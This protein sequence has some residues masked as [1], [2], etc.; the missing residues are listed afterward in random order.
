MSRRFA[1]AAV[2]AGLV[3]A[4]VSGG[5]AWAGAR[6]GPN[7][8]FVGYVNGKSANAVVYTA[9]PGPYRPG[10]LGPPVGDHVYVTRV[11]NGGGDTGANARVIYAYVP[12]GPPA[13]TSL[14]RYGNQGTLP[15]TARV[16]CQG[17]GTVYFTTCPLP[18]PCGAGAKPYDVS[19][20]F[21]NIAV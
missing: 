5:V 18:Q 8:H 14:S 12:G 9:C 6:I 7:Q 2:T 16:P 20:T 11:P 15:N 4:P 19:V 10:E 17:T 3:I 21:E 1:I 13:I